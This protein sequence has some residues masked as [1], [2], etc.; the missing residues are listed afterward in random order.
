MPH[1]LDLIFTFTGGLT[2]ALLFGFLTKRLGLSP[3]VGYLIAG[4]AVSPHTPGFDADEGLAAQMAEIGV[5]L[6]MFGVGLQFHLKELLAVRRIAIP[7][8]LAQIAVATALG[9]GVTHLFG[10][11]LTAGLVFGLAISV[12][13]TVVLIRVLSDHGALHTRTGHIAIGWLVV[14]DIFTVVALVVLPAVLGGAGVAAAGAAA[15]GTG[16]AGALG[17]ALLKLAALVG[18]TALLGR[19]VIPRLLDYVARTGSRELFMLTILVLALG[20]AVGSAKL[21]GAS[22][23][24]GAFLAGMVVGQSEYSNRAASEALPFRDAFAVLFFVSVGMLFD[25]RQLASDWP[26]IL[27]V[28]AVVILGKSLAALIVVRLLRYPFH[29]ALGVA[30]ALAQIGEFSFILASLGRDLGVL[31]A[32]ALNILVSTAILSITL[33]PLLYKATPSIVRWIDRH[34]RLARWLN[35]PEPETQAPEREADTDEHRAIVVGYGPVGRTLKRIL[36]RNGIR[37]VIVEMNLDTV[38]SLR[39]SGTDAVYGEASKRETLVAAGIAR[40]DALILTASN[41][42]HADE[43]IR[44]ARELNPDIHI[45]ARANYLN[46]AVALDR[47]GA[48]RIVTAEGEVALSMTEFL[49]RSLGATYEQIDH[50]RDRV[51]KELF[52]D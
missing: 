16:L 47:A 46:E 22:M 2:A 21:F 29:V 14:E 1:D 26:L 27:M 4:I 23:A 28:T 41:V 17:F 34:P 38:R 10:W 48:H 15:T 8:A 3:I 12:A 40:A 35:P 13:S 11:Q 30:V 51:R 33:N 24:L 50:E 44:I 5:I 37:P 45:L 42:A 32:N 7:G 39:A 36:L 49:L 20:I 25:F 18:L 52:G 6:L 19:Y 43:A 31:P 9:A